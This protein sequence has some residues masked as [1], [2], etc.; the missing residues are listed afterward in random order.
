[1][2]GIW[3][4]VVPVKTAVGFRPTAIANKVR[5]DSARNHKEWDMDHGGA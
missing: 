1:M 4:L 5:S 3:L 2:V